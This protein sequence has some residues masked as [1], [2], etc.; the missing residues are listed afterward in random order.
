MWYQS[1]RTMRKLLLL[2]FLLFT[3][4]LH[5]YGTNGCTNKTVILIH[6]DGPNGIK[7]FTEEDCDGNGHFTVTANGDVNTDTTKK[8]LGPSAALF[9]G[10]GDFLQINAIPAVGTQDFTEDFWANIANVGVQEYFQNLGLVQN[11]FDIRFLAG[12]LQVYLNNT[13][14][15]FAWSPSSGVWYHIR[16]TRKGTNLKAWVD[17]VQIGTTQTS[18]D[19]IPSAD[20][21]IGEINGVVFYQGSID[22]YRMVIGTAYEPE[23]G[24]TNPTTPYCMGCEMMGVL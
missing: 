13:S 10:S 17:E 11:Y 18:S 3:T 4:P 1:Q 24:Q 20:L 2:S 19:S 7:S 15:L 9:D 8:V 22:E 12:N 16:I 5:A 23:I 6:M 14:Y 21:Y